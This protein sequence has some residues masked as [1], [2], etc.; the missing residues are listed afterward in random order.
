MS[1]MGDL[2]WLLLPNGVHLLALLTVVA[3]A[4]SCSRSRRLAR[5]RAPAWAAVG[6]VWVLTT[7]AIAN[8]LLRSLEGPLQPPP[9]AERDERTR[10]LVLASG[11]LLADDGT[12][13]ARLDE[14][15]WERAAAGVELWR[16][17]G[18]VLVYSGGPDGDPQVSL[19]ASM[20]AV[21]QA[22]G[23]PASAI[24]RSPSGANT[25]DEMAGAR[26]E[27]AG[28]GPRWLV[29]SASHMP[30]SLRVA[31]CLGLTLKPYPVGPRQI[32]NVTWVS[33]L[34]DPTAPEVFRSTLHEWV[35]MAYYR[36]RH[37]C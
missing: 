22:M 26:A 1:T 15:G 4:V 17:T 34:P 37:G 29:T 36:L 23:V 32:V 30:R 21:A 18:G 19:A 12:A 16:R 14:N 24:V 2:L 9:K 10:I 28:D 35:G 7:P 25:F 11:Q 20:A 6:V 31:A 27:M 33:W 5:W 13:V 3:I 8:E